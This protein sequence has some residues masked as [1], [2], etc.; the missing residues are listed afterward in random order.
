MTPIWDMSGSSPSNEACGQS[1]TRLIQAQWSVGDNGA[2]RAL[3]LIIRA[4]CQKTVWSR[5]AAG[6]SFAAYSSAELGYKQS[7]FG[8]GFKGVPIGLLDESISNQAIKSSPFVCVQS[9]SPLRIP[10]SH[11]IAQDRQFFVGD[12]ASFCHFDCETSATPGAS[13]H[14]YSQTAEPLRG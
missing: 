14:G 2:S 9:F 8:G 11:Y 4:F 6:S 3:N 7:G 5:S 1:S 13:A 10:S 12:D